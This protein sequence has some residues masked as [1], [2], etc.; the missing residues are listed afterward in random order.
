[1]RTAFLYSKVFL[2][3]AISKAFKRHDPSEGYF[4]VIDGGEGSGKGTVIERLKGKYPAIEFSREPGG[5]PY[6][7]EIR[8]VMLQSKYAKEANAITQFLLV[9]AGRA[10]HMARKAEEV[11]ASGRHFVT[12]RSDS[13]SWGYQIGGQ[14]GG[15]NVKKLFF[16]V[17]KAVYKNI[18][19]DLHI[20]LEVDPKE[21]ARR[22]AARKGE[23]NHF[24]ERKRDFH[25]RVMKAYR[26]FGKLFPGEVRFVDA[27][28][29]KDEV[30]AEVDSMLS[31][32]ILK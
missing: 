29:S 2:T 24:D 9:S 22:V 27:N 20:I 14:E 8:A 21:G 10:D 5:T 28:R 25:E 6:A 17:R 13:T 15:Y 16:A 32:Y 19:P 11:I 4:I 3:N 1:M 31:S 26:T 12:D 18:R 23:I 7:E 30:F